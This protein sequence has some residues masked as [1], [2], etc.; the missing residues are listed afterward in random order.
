M[1]ASIIPITFEH[2]YYFQ[3]NATCQWFVWLL[4]IGFGI[5]FSTLFAKTYRVNTIIASSRKCRRV[6]ISIAQTLY[7]V[8]I[9]LMCMYDL[10]VL[11]MC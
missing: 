6:K 9:I 8:A 4:T 11:F 3:T 1:T 7:P 5:T 10:V 2:W